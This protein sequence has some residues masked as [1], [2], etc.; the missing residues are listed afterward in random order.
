MELVN[1]SRL[2]SALADETTDILCQE[3]LTLCACYTSDDFTI[4]ECFLQFVPISNLSS[5]SLAPT[6]LNKFSQ[7][8]VDVSKMRGQ[9]YDGAAAMSGKL[10]GALAHIR[11]VILRLYMYTAQRRCNIAAATDEEY[12]R[13]AN[14]YTIFR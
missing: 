11:D 8:G 13:A 4:E 14:F 12:F 1:R 3:Q 7:I 9:V 6:I 5:K 2:F 10:N